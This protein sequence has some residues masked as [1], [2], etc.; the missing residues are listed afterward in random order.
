M[1]TLQTKQLTLSAECA[2]SNSSSWIVLLLLTLM[3]SACTGGRGS[4]QA[5]PGDLYPMTPDQKQRHDQILLEIDLRTRQDIRDAEE[6]TESERKRQQI[7]QQKKKVVPKKKSRK[8]I[9]LDEE[10]FSNELQDGSAP[11]EPGMIVRVDRERARARPA[12]PSAGEIENLTQ[13]GAQE[14]VLGLGFFHET[15]PGDRN[16][17]IGVQALYRGWMGNNSLIQFGGWVDP[18]DLGVS[19]GRGGLSLGAIFFLKDSI[20]GEPITFY[21]S[22]NYLFNGRYVAGSLSIYSPLWPGRMGV[23]H[24]YLAPGIVIGYND[25]VDNAVGIAAGAKVGFVVGL[26]QRH[27]LYLEL[28]ALYQFNAPALTT[29]FTLAPGLGFSWGF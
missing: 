19:N 22:M 4:Y 11:D 18:I 1:L 13:P 15:Q 26:F 12:S 5:G 29:K 9:E 7:E 25:Q 21:P 10:S 28:S 27:A 2:P 17:R 14:L 16:I 23:A 20:I 24:P 6:R 3:L 8:A